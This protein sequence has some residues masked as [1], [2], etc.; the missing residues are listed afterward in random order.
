MSISVTSDLQ[1][2]N[3]V[4]ARSGM[5]IEFTANNVG[6]TIFSV[7]FGVK[8]WSGLKSAVPSN[9]Q[10]QVQI[11]ST[12]IE[13]GRRSYM[14]EVSDFIKTALSKQDINDKGSRATWVQ[15][16]YIVLTDDGSTN[17]I[18]GGTLNCSAVTGWS[19]TDAGKV[20]SEYHLP[21]G[22]YYVAEDTDYKFQVLDFANANGSRTLQEISFTYEDG[23]GGSIT[24]AD[25]PTIDST[26]IHQLITIPMI[27]HTSAAVR[28][29]SDT[30]TLDTFRVEVR[31]RDKYGIRKLDYKDRNGT[32]S[33]LYLFGRSN[34][35]QSVERET[36]RRSTLPASNTVKYAICDVNGRESEELNTD[37]V[38]EDYDDIIQDILLTEQAELDG[39]RVNVTD[40]SKTYK[41]SVNELINYSLNVKFADD[42]ILNI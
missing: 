21:G 6:E 22:T 25:T 12:A 4:K 28:L 9:P 26:E 42:T 24:L 37:F 13:L 39:R 16:E 10:F 8:L 32:T 18:Y 15:I 1:N 34:R 31:C 19:D 33:S 14:V 5:K 17:S 27:G 38:T 35:T 41:E 20:A 11:P 2:D 23:T 7:S 40:T 3:I 29:Q 30:V 36:F